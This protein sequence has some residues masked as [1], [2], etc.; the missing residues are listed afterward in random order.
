MHRIAARSVGRLAPMRFEIATVH[1]VFARACNLEMPDSTL[2][3]L[4]DCRLGNAPHGIACEVPESFTFNAVIRPGTKV[5][6]RTGELALEHTALVIDLSRA[7]RWDGAVSQHVVDPTSPATC[8]SLAML[9]RMLQASS[10]SG[11][12]FACWSLPDEAASPLHAALQRRLA[13]TL[14]LLARAT[15]A[16]DA[17]MIETAL[18]AI[19]G[20][21]VGLTPSGDDLIVGYLAALWSQI[22]L[23]ATLQPLLEQLRAP[24]QSMTTKTGAISRQFILDASE[25]E[26]SEPLVDLVRAIAD[27][28]DERVAIT[29]ARALR[30]GHSSGADAVLGLLLGWDPRAFAA[31]ILDH[32]ISDHPISDH[33][34]S[35]HPVSHHPES[36]HPVAIQPVANTTVENQP[37]PIALDA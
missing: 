26:F 20:L 16:R 24:M 30:I 36:D 6:V 34:V 3:T 18:S 31:P 37:E 1:S 27:G 14:P 25:G 9:W 7:V 19:I 32:P 17:I 8:N 12:L 33:L 2:V 10:R 11:G 15:V 29:A 22:S 23:D 28:D 21:G 5:S 35:D 4:L 13:T